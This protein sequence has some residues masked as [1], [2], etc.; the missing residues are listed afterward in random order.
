MMDALSP[1]GGVVVE[2]G[3]FEGT[4]SR[5]LLDRL[6][7]RQLI[8]I[9]TWQGV[10]G[11]GNA[12]G[13]NYHEV[14]LNAT[15]EQLS[16]SIGLDP[17]VTLVRDKSQ[18]A[19]S[20]LENESIDVVYLDAD[21]SYEATLGDLHMA[22]SKLKPG[23]ILAGHDYEINHAKARTAWSFGVKRAVDEF[24]ATHQLDF[25]AKA[26]DGCVSFAI[27]KP[28]QQELNDDLP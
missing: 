22:W 7:P 19:L 25:I 14:D 16:N 24:V 17:R 6:Q 1:R 10:C 9:D 21:H 18:Q 4:F 27:R 23:G 15:Y 28:E 20:C 12:D 8:L 5:E 3:V 2:V 13:N 11:S 26:M